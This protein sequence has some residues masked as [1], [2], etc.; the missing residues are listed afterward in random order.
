VT[1]VRVIQISTT[2]PGQKGIGNARFQINVERTRIGRKR[3]KAVH[4]A[5]HWNA[6]IQNKDT[7]EVLKTSRASAMVPAGRILEHW[8][9]QYL[10]QGYTV[11]VTGDFNWREKGKSSDWWWAPENIFKRCGMHHFSVGLD[12]LAYSHDVIPRKPIQIIPAGTG[13]NHSDHPWIVGVF[14]YRK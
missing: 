8:I 1:K 10:A 14:K 3:R 6:V 7:G 13:G 5:T 2:Q 12:W 9:K 4:I 11:F